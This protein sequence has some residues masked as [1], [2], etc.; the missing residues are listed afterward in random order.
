[1]IGSES[2]TVGS[3]LMNSESSRS[4]AIFTILIHKKTSD[5]ASTS[6]F[7]FVDL[8]GSERLSRTKAEG[9]RMKEGTPYQLQL[10][11]NTFPR[12]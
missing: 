4:H 2:R 8:A 1:V 9:A 6:K 3:T 12:N 5:S 10:D 11:T 7:H